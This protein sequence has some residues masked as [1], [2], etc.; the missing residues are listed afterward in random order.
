MNLETI[1]FKTLRM[2]VATAQQ[3]SFTRASEELSVPKSAVSKAI[4]RLEAE[5]GVRL[6]ERSSRVV[7]LTEPGT[8]LLNRARSLLEET[9]LMFADVQSSHRRV[10]GQLRL[11]A[12]PALG[13]YISR[14]LLPL[15]L[16]DWPEVNVSLKLS[17]DYEDLFREGLDLA[18]R[19]GGP[20]DDNLIEKKLGYANRVVVAA[21]EYLERYGQI[22]DPQQLP[23][24]RCLQ[25][26]D[27]PF[28]DWTLAQGGNS[29][30]VTVPRVFQCSDMEAL[31][32]MLLAG[33]GVAQ[34]PWL[35]VRDEIQQGNLVEVLPGWVSSGLSV[36][37]V[38]RFGVN[39]PAK[40]AEFL[41][42]IDRHQHLF[43]L[44]RYSQ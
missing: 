28:I 37:A 16:A 41:A 1:D 39:K 19:M 4:R 10:S 30:V 5:L 42:L 33:V 40:L 21:P 7:R 35:V 18:F 14:E 38:Y 24:H 27:R 20:R 22:T 26:F 44:Q 2:F 12:P 29:H 8:I 3:L 11:A 36:S 43:D 6:F 31:K 13:R 17:Y 23:A 32:S 9:S 25:V 15:F 34:L